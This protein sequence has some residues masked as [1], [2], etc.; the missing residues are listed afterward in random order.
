VTPNQAIAGYLQ[1]ITAAPI[2]I[3]PN[4]VEVAHFQK[5]APVPA[6]YASDPRPKIVFVGSI[7]HWIDLTLVHNLAKASPDLSFYMIGPHQGRQLPDRSENLHYLGSVGYE[8]I[9]GYLQHA[10]VALAPFDVEGRR[11]LVES[12]DALKLYEYIVSDLPVVATKWQQ[13]QRLE[14]Y[15]LATDQTSEAFRSAIDQ[16]L[17]YP[18]QHKASVSQKAEFDWSTRLNELDIPGLHKVP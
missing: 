15:V 3:V 9:P 12:V 13:S 8:L 2:E 5:A 6:A 7:A 1:Q 10:D 16:A 11:D 17:A 4:G 18:Q 14:P